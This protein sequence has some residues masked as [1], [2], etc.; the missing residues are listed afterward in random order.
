MVTGVPQ[1]MLQIDRIVSDTDCRPHT[2]NGERGTEDGERGTG[3]RARRTEN[4]AQD[5]TGTVSLPT[6]RLIRPNESQLVPTRRR[7]LHLGFK[8]FTAHPTMMMS[9]PEQLVVTGVATRIVANRS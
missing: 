7:V 1:D 6:R 9:P 5:T 3:E 4:G 8:I 2:E